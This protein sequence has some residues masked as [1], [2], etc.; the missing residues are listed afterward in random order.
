MFLNAK[1]QF[2]RFIQISFQLFKIHRKGTNHIT[3][4]ILP[5]LFQ[6]PAR[7]C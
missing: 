5:G 6:L 1:L 4:E 3:T 2:L 7:L